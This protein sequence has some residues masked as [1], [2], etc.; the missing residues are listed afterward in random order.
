LAYFIG[1]PR[2]HRRQIS[3]GASVAGPFFTVIL[4]ARRLHFPC[5]LQELIPY[6]RRPATDEIASNTRFGDMAGRG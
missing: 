6:L 2:R 3:S 1:S 5:S 4:L